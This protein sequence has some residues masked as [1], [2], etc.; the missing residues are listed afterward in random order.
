MVLKIKLTKQVYMFTTFQ[1]KTKAFVLSTLLLG[2]SSMDQTPVFDLY[3][4]EITQF[5][6]IYNLPILASIAQEPTNLKSVL[7]QKEVEISTNTLANVQWINIQPKKSTIKHLNKTQKTVK[8]STSK[9]GVLVVK[10]YKECQNSTEVNLENF[11]FGSMN[12]IAVLN[13]NFEI[14]DSFYNLRLAFRPKKAL[15]YDFILNTGVQEIN[16]KLYFKRPS[17]VVFG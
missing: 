13:K 10:T 12:T 4:T 15:D 11:S 3:K 14:I 5:Y 6:G 16:Y 8:P 17:A 7:V 9:N 2:I 1:F